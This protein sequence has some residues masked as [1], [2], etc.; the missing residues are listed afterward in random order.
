VT[1]F[2]AYR[3][4]CECEVITPSGAMHTIER[5]KT[6]FWSPNGMICFLF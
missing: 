2:A 4:R 3:L 6:S 1:T 5:V